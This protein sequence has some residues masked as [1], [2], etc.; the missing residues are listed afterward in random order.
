MR[1]YEKVQ[2]PRENR[3]YIYNLLLGTTSLASMA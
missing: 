3:G 1:L 2:R